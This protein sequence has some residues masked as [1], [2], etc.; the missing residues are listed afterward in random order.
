MCMRQYPEWHTEAFYNQLQLQYNKFKRKELVFIMSDLNAHIGK[1][2]LTD[3]FSGPH[4]CGKRNWNGEHFAAFLTSN[5][6]Y[7][8]NS[9]FKHPVRHVT[10][11]HGIISKTNK[12]KN[13][14][15][16]GNNTDEPTVHHI[17]KKF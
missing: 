11:W 13:S 6:L 1:R 10:T 9:H 16:I 4:T 17:D 7:I 2:I 5:N 3:S 14:S 12:S 8:N 15:D